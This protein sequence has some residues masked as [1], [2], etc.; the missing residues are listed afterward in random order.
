[1][2]AIQ[3]ALRAAAEQLERTGGVSVVYRR[4]R[5][6]FEIVAIP[7][8]YKKENQEIVHGQA[9][10]KELRDFII[11]ADRLPV[12]PENGDK[13]VWDKTEY[14]LVSMD[15]ERIFRYMDAYKI[16]LRV[17]TQEI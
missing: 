13:I 10:G 9:C 14:E 3:T 15:D 16:A 2:N 17:H 8:V 6:K 7:S 12:I 5:R 1:M 11:I 4:G